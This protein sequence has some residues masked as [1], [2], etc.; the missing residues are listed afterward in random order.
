MKNLFYSLMEEWKKLGLKGENRRGGGGNS[1]P[2][3]GESSV[4]WEGIKKRR[5]GG[6]LTP[7]GTQPPGKMRK[8]SGCKSKKKQSWFY[9][10]R[11]FGSGKSFPFYAGN[12]KRTTLAFQGWTRKQDKKGIEVGKW[13]HEKA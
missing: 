2:E 8:G 12:A 4:G 1:T 3:G 7:V 9:R 11:E 6:G 13:K 10:A 5:G